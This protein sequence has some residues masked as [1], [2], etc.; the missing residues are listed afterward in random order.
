MI[1]LSTLNPYL[2]Y[3][4]I[5][6]VALLVAGLFWLGWHEMGIRA[7]LK[8]KTAEAALNKATSEMY[9]KQFNDYIQLQREITDAIKTIKVQSNNYIQTIEASGPP[10]ADGVTFVLVPSGVPK[11]LSFATGFQNYSAGGAVPRAP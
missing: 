4:K 3:I 10:A 9:A 11:A 5:G 6:A 8:N 2:L 7:D 1:S